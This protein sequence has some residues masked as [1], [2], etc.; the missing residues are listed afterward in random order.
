VTHDILDEKLTVL[1]RPTSCSGLAYRLDTRAARAMQSVT[2]PTQLSRMLHSSVS[3][4]H[5]PTRIT[6]PGV[7]HICGEI[8]WIVVV[9]GDLRACNLGVSYAHTLRD[10]R[11]QSARC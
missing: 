7:D 10:C 4:V 1:I 8:T 3:E 11:C 6:Y 2:T 5:P 9:E